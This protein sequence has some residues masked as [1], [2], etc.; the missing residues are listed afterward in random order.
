MHAYTPLVGVELE[1]SD[2][3]YAVPASAKGEPGFV[4]LCVFVCLC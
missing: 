2:M 1:K 4:F 3:L